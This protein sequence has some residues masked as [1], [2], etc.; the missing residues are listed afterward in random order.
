MR[1]HHASCEAMNQV[2]LC[3]WRHKSGEAIAQ[4]TTYEVKPRDW[5]SLE[6]AL[7]PF[8]LAEGQTTTF[9]L[10]DVGTFFFSIG[11]LRA[12]FDTCGLWWSINK[13]LLIPLRL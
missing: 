5:Q 6:G 2:R 10:V 9:R 4:V 3:R 7:F 1:R 8:R 13:V 11:S 12:F